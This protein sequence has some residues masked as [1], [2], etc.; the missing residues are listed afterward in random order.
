MIN[1][2]VK[3]IDG[4]ENNMI[5]KEIY[6]KPMTIKDYAELYEM[7]SNIPGIGLSEADSE[8]AISSYL[9]RNPD[10]SYV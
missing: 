5:N 7:W 6:I 1:Y 8:E 9:K 2:A 10:L 4:G 3:V